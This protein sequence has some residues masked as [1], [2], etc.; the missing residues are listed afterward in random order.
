MIAAIL[1]DAGAMIVLTGA[2]VGASGALL[3]TFLVL[4]GQAMLT[5][6]IAHSI[7]LGIVVVWLLTG[8]TSGPLQIIGA[9]LTGVLTVA[10]TE[11]LARSRLVGMDAA[12][13]LVF[14]ALFAAGVLLIN[15]YARD[16]HIDADA[17]LL[18]EIGFVWLNTVSVA[19]LEVPQAVLSLAVLLAVNLGFVGLLWKELKLATFDGALAAALGFAPGVLFYALLTLTSATAVASFDA[20]GAILF[21]AFVIVPP[22][23]ALLL[24]DRLGLAVGIAIGLAVAASAAGYGLALVWDVSIGGMMASVTGVFFAT[25]LLIAPRNGV[26]A[27]MLR[28]REQALDHDCRTLVAHL[29]SHHDRPEVSRENTP[30]ALRDHLRWPAAKAD[31]VILQSLDRDFIRREGGLLALTDK[32]MAVARE[33]FEPWARRKA[34]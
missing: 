25:A 10:L 29:Y 17:V 23:T 31:R 28:Q 33:I 2:L 1:A 5:D 22:A 18:G 8:A 7:V 26:F 30:E 19:G 32:G 34:G 13:G 4:R 11:A 9:A 16:V 20:V 14:P 21:I 12:V 15:L 24:T 27:R 3:G 6:A